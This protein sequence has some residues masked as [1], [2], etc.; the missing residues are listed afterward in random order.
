MRSVF[1]QYFIHHWMLYL[2]R[3][4]PESVQLLKRID[5]Q[6]LPA[7]TTIVA[8]KSS[9][10]QIRRQRSC[11]SRR[12]GPGPLEVVAAQPAGHVNHFANEIE[13]RL[14]F[15]LHGLRAQLARVH[16]AAHDLGLTPA[17]AAIGCELPALQLAGQ[18]LQVLVLALG[19]GAGAVDLQAVQ[20][21]LHPALGEQLAQLLPKL[22]LGDALALA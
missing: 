14:S 4:Y 21:G 10:C 22:A 2:K 6:G 9:A 8:R 15:A 16:A 20:P 12:T 3:V 17:L 7:K 18:G 13:P 1:A 5:T 11:T 19:H